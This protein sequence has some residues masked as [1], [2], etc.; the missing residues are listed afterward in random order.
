M[1]QR[2]MLKDGIGCVQL[3]KIYYLT[4]SFIF[5]LFLLF[6]LGADTLFH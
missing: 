4:D 6:K 3:G 1:L 5:N 2:S